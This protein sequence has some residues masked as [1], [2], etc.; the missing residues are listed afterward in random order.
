MSVM[1]RVCL[2]GVPEQE[3]ANVSLQI[4]SSLISRPVAEITGSPA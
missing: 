1:L 2:T 4:S 3:Y